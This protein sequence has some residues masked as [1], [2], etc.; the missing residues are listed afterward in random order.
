MIATITAFVHTHTKEALFW[1]Q[2]KLAFG[3]I[4]LI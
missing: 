4:L 3:K 1:K 2:P